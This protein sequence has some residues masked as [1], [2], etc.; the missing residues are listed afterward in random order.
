MT[1]VT[2]SVVFDAADDD[3]VAQNQTPGAA[4]NLTLNGALVTSG[5]ATLCAAGLERQVLVTTVSDESAKTL[6]IYGTNATGNSISETITGPNATTGTTTKYFRTVTR[7]A[8]SAAFTGNVRV[9][10]NGVGASRPISL[11]YNQRQFNVTYAC[12]ITGTV[13]YDIEHTLDDL[14]DSTITTPYWFD[15]ANLAGETTDQF[16]SITY[17]VRFSRIKMNS[18]TGTVRATVIQAGGYS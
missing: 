18:G 8:V 11:D 2:I 7:V 1:P 4:G 6:T 10:T 13:N 14:N 9:G 3:G 12:D 15:D 16:G 17:P 5:T